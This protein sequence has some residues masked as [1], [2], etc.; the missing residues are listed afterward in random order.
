[1]KFKDLIQDNGFLTQ[2]G[3][4]YL[5]PLK[6]TIKTFLSQIDEDKDEQTIMVIEAIFAK[7]IADIFASL[8]QKIRYKNKED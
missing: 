1:M 8:K 7:E 6:E 5:S 3:K 4:E 2:A